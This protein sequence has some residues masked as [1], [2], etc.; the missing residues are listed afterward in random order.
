[1][2][3]NSKYIIQFAIIL[4]S[5][6]FTGRLFSI[7]ILDKNY[8]LAAEDNAMRP[9]IEYPYRGVIYDRNGKLIVHNTPVYDL[10]V[11]P[12]EVKIKDTLAFCQMVGITKKEFEDRLKTL[13]KQHRYALPSVLVKQIPSEEF[14]KI[15]SLLLDYPGFNIVARTVR[16]YPYGSLANALGYMREIDQK[17]L[18]RDT[19]NYYKKGDY[20]GISGVEASY[21]EPLR[22]KRGVQYKMVNAIGVVKGSFNNGTFD[23]LSIPGQN[24][25]ASI[26][27]TLQNYAEKLLNGKR[28]SVVAIEPSTGEILSIVSRP[29]YNPNILSGRDLS[30]NYRTLTQDTLKPLFNRPIMAT[31]PPGS[32]FKTLQA[33]IALQEG[34]ITPGEQIY[35]DGLLI[36]D[37]APP[38]YY[39]VHRGIKY[40]SNNYFFKVFRRIINQKKH[41][42]TFIDARIGLTNWRKYVAGFGLGH[43]LGVDIPNEKGGHIPD[44]SYYDRFYGKNRWKFSNIYSLSI[45]QGEMLMTPIQMANLAAILANRGYYYTPHII[46]GVADE[47]QPL[48]E[49]RKKHFSGI[50]SS[51]FSPVIDAMQEALAGTAGRAIIRDIE[52][53]G[54]TGTA[55][56]PHGEDHSVFM[57]FAPKKD[58]KIAIA[59][60]VENAGWGGR[61]AASTASL[62]IEKYIR[63]EITRPWLEDYVLQGKF[64]Y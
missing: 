60:Y 16:G 31:Y 7:Q 17:G 2:N 18:D 47:N 9:I 45:G 34:V 61:A 25:H 42:N 28:G 12:K 1:M 6:I 22:G 39:N 11:I 56:N 19:V 29:S 58:P 36:G 46:K 41:E 62:M 57:A 30:K 50:D 64:I 38:G 14:A 63:G 48:P 55:E 40:S 33:L 32:I 20:I 53:C 51:Y 44:T 37:H 10:M 52:I 26:D 35:C 54:K 13:K 21:E 59:V 23:T 49:Y 43:R 27:I 3:N 4:V 5:L 8:K 15:Q 24:L